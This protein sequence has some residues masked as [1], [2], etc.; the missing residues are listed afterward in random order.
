MK[1]ECLGGTGDLAVW[2]VES[3]SEHFL[4][5][6]QEYLRLSFK[7]GRAKLNPMLGREDEVLRQLIEGAIKETK[8][9]QRQQRNG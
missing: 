2:H 3:E 9:L 5:R 8:A 1:A 6:G 4:K 7:S